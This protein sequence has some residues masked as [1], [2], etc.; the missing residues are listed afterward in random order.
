MIKLEK[1]RHLNSSLKFLNNTYNT[2]L[3]SKKR[4]IFIS[5]KMTSTLLRSTNTK[6]VLVIIDFANII[7]LIQM[8]GLIL[9]PLLY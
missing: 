7:D 9:I 1:L 4:R 5:T 6:I 2:D 3:G 8:E